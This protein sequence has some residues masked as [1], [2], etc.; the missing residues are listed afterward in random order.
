MSGE[1]YPLQLD[2]VDAYSSGLAA[3][4]GAQAIVAAA[5]KD[6]LDL[7]STATNAALGI[8]LAANYV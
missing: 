1:Y 2:T 3:N 4:A 6:D 5:I 8:F 7:S